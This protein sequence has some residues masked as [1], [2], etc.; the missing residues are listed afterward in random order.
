MVNFIK[1]K[2]KVLVRSFLKHFKLSILNTELVDK[3]DNPF[4]VISKIL[5]NSETKTIVDGGASVGNTSKEL[6]KLFP[7]AV[8]HA[9]EP[10][11]KFFQTL[12]EACKSEKR[13][14]SYQYALSNNDGTMLLNINKS[15]ATNSLLRTEIQKNHPHCDLLAST[16]TTKVEIKTLD[17]LFASEEIDVLKLDLQGGEYDALIGANN[18]LIKGKIK[19]IICEVLFEKCYQNQRKASDLINFIESKGFEILNFY[20][21]NYHHGRLLQSDVVFYHKSIAELIVKETS[22]GFMPHS[23]YLNLV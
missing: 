12:Q 9:F 20:Q 21:C 15:E 19:I 8:V 7:N 1:V 2:L 3:S 18:L 6:A 13:I 17:S 16:G 22:K 14:I 4:F 5:T 11:P 10:F 23:K